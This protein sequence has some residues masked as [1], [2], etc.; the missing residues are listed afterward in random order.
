[1]IDQLAEKYITTSPYAFV[2]N[3]PLINR[4]IDGR[5]F[6]KKNEK[7]AQKIEKKLDKQIAKLNKEINKLQK[8]GQST[9]DRNDRVAQLNKSKSDVSDMRGDTNNFYKFEKASQN[10]GAPETKRTGA[11]EITM[12]TDNFSKQIHEG[13]HGGQIARGEYNIDMSGSVISGNFGVSKEIDA[14]KAQYSYDGKIEYVPSINMA[15]DL[16]KLMTQG[17]MGFK[18]TIS[19]MS[20]INNTFIQSLVDN[21]GINQA[22]IYPDPAVNPTYYQQ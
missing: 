16:M 20:Q 6:D 13:R 9:G 1:M 15:T 14:Y 21:P 10:N 12:F 17:V 18:Q 2:Q 22:P 7:K 8:K 11:N 4:E 19:N 3:N 5:E